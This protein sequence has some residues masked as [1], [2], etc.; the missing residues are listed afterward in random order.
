[1]TDSV[2]SN[3]PVDPTLDLIARWDAE[4]ATDDPDEIVRRQREAEE[5]MQS[6]ARSRREMEGQTRGGSG[7]ETTADAR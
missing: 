5:F 3:G 6:L 2:S 7:H 1:M 4:D